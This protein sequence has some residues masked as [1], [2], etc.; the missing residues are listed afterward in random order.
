MMTSKNLTK[1]SFALAQLLLT[2][3]FKVFVRVALAQAP[4]VLD[5][6]DATI[7]KIS[8]LR[9]FL[10]S[11]DPLTTDSNFF[12]PSNCLKFVKCCCLFRSTGGCWF[13]ALLA[14]KP[15]NVPWRLSYLESCFYCKTRTQ[16]TFQAS[17]QSLTWV[18]ITRAAWSLRFSFRPRSLVKPSRSGSC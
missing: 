1:F 12:Q 8:Q 18:N 9:V 14:N 17:F 15:W 6:F 5:A 4:Q 7:K 11:I 16:L 2:L 13:L 10:S 3:Y